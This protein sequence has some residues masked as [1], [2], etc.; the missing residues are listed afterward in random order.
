MLRE[1]NEGRRGRGVRGMLLG[2][3][4]TA[5]VVVTACVHGPPGVGGAPGAPPSPHDVWV[6]PVEARRVAESIASPTTVD[7]TKITPQMLAEAAKGLTLTQVVDLALTNNPATR[8]SWL[9]ARAAADAYGQARGSLFPGLSAS[10]TGL[11]SK[12]V[13]SNVRFGG[14]RNQISPSLNLSWLVLDVG[15]RSGSREAAREAT[16]AAGFHHDAVIQSAVLQAETAY[17]GYMA[18][19]ALLQAQQASVTEAEANLQAAQHRHDVGLATIADVLQARTAAS[20]TRLAVETTQGQL[21]AARATVAVAMGLPAN[22][23]FDIAPPPEQTSVGTVSE[24]VDSLIAEA[25]RSRPDL[26][27][28][29]ASARQAYA[30][31]R[32]TRSGGLPT[33]SLSGNAGRVISDV[34]ELS[35]TSYSLSLGLSIP[36]FTG[37]AQTYANRAAEARA[38]AADA[39]AEGLRQQVIQ[40]VFTSYYALQTATQRVHTTDDLLASAEQSEQVAHGRYNEGVGTIL[41][42]LTAQQALADARAQ[43]SQA[44]WSWLL[45]LAQLAHDGGVLGTNGAAAIPVAQ[46]STSN[47]LR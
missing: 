21:Q 17:F 18:T 47:R 28:A 3:A 7:T 43:Q 26:A 2:T 1:E 32:V 24:S 13:A 16:Y 25:V 10:A 45:A 44:R 39:Q 31:A 9:Q 46:D 40:Q 37:F 34:S 5:V 20:Q 38:A 33:L 4:A 23:P 11:T 12:Q 29:E 6:P 42:L 14:T 30:S 36:L 8:V 27:A 41:D 35:G 22:A 15:G 19:R